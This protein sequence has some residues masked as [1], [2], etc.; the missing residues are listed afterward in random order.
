MSHKGIHWLTQFN[1]DAR[2]LE[3][4][5]NEEQLEDLNRVSTNGIK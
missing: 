4:S 3:E 2:R 1:N 5:K